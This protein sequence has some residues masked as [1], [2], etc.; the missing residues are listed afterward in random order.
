MLRFTRQSGQSQTSLLRKR[1]SQRYPLVTR[2][3]D[4]GGTLWRMTA[5][6]SQE[7]LLDRVE[8]EQDLHHFPYGMLLWHSAI[9]L[10]RHFAEH[11]NEV[12]CKRVLEIGAGA[13][14][15]GIIAASL[16]ATVTQTDY[17]TDPLLLAR[18]N[19]ADNGLL[20]LDVKDSTL[21]VQDSTLNAQHSTL[22]QRAGDWRDWNVAGPFDLVIGSDVLYERTLHYE[23]KRLLARYSREGARIL[24]SDP[25]RPQAMEFVA[26]LE[27]QE[28]TVEMESRQ[29]YW[30]GEDKEIVLFDLAAPDR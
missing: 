28:W 4:I 29:V 26:Q 25:V 19:A 18:V 10:A 2:S 1:L 3:V 7:A 6:D 12:R 9:G 16:G 21:E 30:E 20:T 27:K 13:G 24:L 15:P 5:A 11:P 22:T 23:L 8:T 14:L 17:Q